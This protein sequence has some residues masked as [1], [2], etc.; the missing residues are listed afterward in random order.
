MWLFD[1]K[2]LYGRKAGGLGQQQDRYKLYREID[3]RYCRVLCPPPDS[4]L[5][6]GD[7]ALVVE[8]TSVR[9][10][11]VSLTF[12]ARDSAEQQQWL[13]DISSS[14]EAL[15]KRNRQAPRGDMFG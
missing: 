6:N 12:W 5:E 13:R 15:L 10:Q 1:D 7:R 2:L 9:G 14:I 11:G 3:L 8:I 4:S